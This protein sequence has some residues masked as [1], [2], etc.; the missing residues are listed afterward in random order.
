[1]QVEALAA[2]AKTIVTE[3]IEGSSA[4]DYDVKK[5]SNNEGSDKN[6]FGFGNTEE[7]EGMQQDN[8][9]MKKDSDL[10][11]MMLVESSDEDTI[12]EEDKYEGGETDN[13]EE[14]LDVDEDNVQDDSKDQDGEDDI[15][16]PTKK[17]TCIV[18]YDQAG[19]WFSKQQSTNSFFGDDAFHT[20]ML[21]LGHQE[22]D[23]IKTNQLKWLSKGGRTRKDG[24][25]RT[26]Y[27]CPN[28]NQLAFPFLIT[29]VKDNDCHMITVGNL[30]HNHDV[31]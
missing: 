19:H 22:F 13:S 20:A 7:D 15:V 26:I 8:N 18:L 27:S 1:M 6:N 17:W 25:V 5:A 28:Y 29:V 30:P 3:T 14:H 12:T 10:D 24:S 31:S 4:A 16:Q 21:E 11:A 9:E 2:A 23:M